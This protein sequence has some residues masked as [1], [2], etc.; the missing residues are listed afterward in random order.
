M[1][2][3]VLLRN[4][5]VVTRVA[6]DSLGGSWL[7]P[8]PPRAKGSIWARATSRPTPSFAGVIPPWC[9]R[10]SRPGDK[11]IALQYHLRSGG[12]TVHLPLGGA[13][14]TANVLLEEPGAAAAAAGLAL[15]DSQMIEGR[16]FR[17]WTGDL[18]ANATIRITLPGA[19]GDS[20]P[21]LVAL[22]AVL[23]LALAAAA[24]RALPRTPLVSVD[25]LVGELASL[26]A[27]FEGK[28]TE[29]PAAEWSRYRARRERLKAELEAALARESGGR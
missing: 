22:V 23:S 7:V 4:S 25:R 21:I 17:R 24:W 8:L 15:A 1:L 29:T 14:V 19:P 2:D 27:R 9:P 5:G 16:F 20:M 12:Q 10:R 3:L 6:P 26:D 11:Q 28:Q 13:A 18:P